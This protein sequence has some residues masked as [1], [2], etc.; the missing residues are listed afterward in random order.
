M[1]GTSFI[2]LA[3]V[4]W[5]TT[6]TAQALGPDVASPLAVGALRLVVGG[7]VLGSIA[8]AN[9]KSPDLRWLVHPATVFAA[10]GMAAYQPTF[11]SAV[12]RT[13]VA[14]GTVVALGSGPIFVGAIESALTRS[15]PSRR[16][17]MATA[18]ALIGLTVLGLQSGDV[19]LDAVGILLALAAGLAYATYAVAASRL[20]R[21]GPTHESAGVTFGLAAILLL[22]LAFSQDLSWVFSAAGI[23]T[24]A[25][26]AIATTVVAYLLFT[27]GLRTTAATTASTL[28][29]AEPITATILGVVVLAERPDL[30]VWVGVGLIGLGLV[31]ATRRAPEVPE[32][33]PRTP[34]V[35]GNPG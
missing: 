11:F 32:R 30:L 33:I 14:V 3:A 13:S 8:M 12:D 24:V 7:L 27:A 31:L 16:W 10:L 26:L 29:L 9:R 20:A 34:P 6:G 19:E 5:G 17:L 21:I 28:T 2:L 25:W 23:T 22:P 18:P 15:P 35:A 4:L 1:R